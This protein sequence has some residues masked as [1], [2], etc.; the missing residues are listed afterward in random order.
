M[1]PIEFS[2]VIKQITDKLQELSGD[3]LADLYND[4]MESQIKYLGDS[5]FSTS[6]G[7][8]Q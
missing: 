5:L 6:K 8:K 1:E 3:D 2:E 7:S 4:L